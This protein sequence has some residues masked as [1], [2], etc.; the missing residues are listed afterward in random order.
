MTFLKYLGKSE[1]GHTI[2]VVVVA[3]SFARIQQEEG[4]V[5]KFSPFLGEALSHRGEGE[6]E[7]GKVS[8]STGC[9]KR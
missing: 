4:D 9:L 8:T 6:V 1:R 3:P 5:A 2:N 7:I